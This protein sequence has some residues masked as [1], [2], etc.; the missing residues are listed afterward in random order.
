MPSSLQP[1]KDKVRRAKL[2]QKYG[3]T[4]GIERFAEGEIA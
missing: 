2:V 4:E 1:K 3:L